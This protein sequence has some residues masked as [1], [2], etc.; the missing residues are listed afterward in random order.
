[1]QEA[2]QVVIEAPRIP[3]FLDLAS[4]ASEL[5]RGLEDGARLVAQIEPRRWLPVLA[6]GLRLTEQ[7]V[8]GL[9]RQGEVLLLLDGLDEVP[10]PWE[11]DLLVESI[12]RMQRYFNPLHA[13]NH[14]IVACREPAWGTGEAFAQFEKVTIQPMDRETI[15]KYVSRW[16]RA[17][18]GDQATDILQSLEKAL[19][20][21]PAL[22]DFAANPQMSTLLA[23]VEYDGPLPKQQ[24]LLFEHFVR[25]LGKADTNR[26]VRETM[27]GHLIALAIEMQRSTSQTG[28][29]LNALKVP[30]AR[31]LLGRRRQ[32]QNGPQLS[33]QT[34]RE[35]GQALLNTLEV[36]TGLLDVDRSDDLDENRSL[37]RFKH[38]TFQE[39]LAACYYAEEGVD[40]LLKHVTDPA[41][42]N[43]LALTCGV[44]T[45]IDEAEVTKLLEQILQIPELSAG[46]PLLPAMLV[47]WAPRV[48]AASVCLAELASYDLEEETL[49]PARRAHNLI[50][51]LLGDVG[52]KVDIQTRARIADGLGSIFDPRLLRE[53]RWVT[54]P[55]G[56]FL[57]GSEADEAWIQER[58]KR[59]VFLEEFWIQRW[60]V[61][62]AEFRQF[63]ED[64]RGYEN[65]AWWQ[66]EAG[67]HWRNERGIRAPKEWEQNR[68]RGNRP[69]TGVSWWEARAFCRWYTSMNTELPDGWAVQLPHEAQWEKAARGGLSLEAAPG[70]ISDTDERYFPWGNTWQDGTANCAATNL[71]HVVPVGLFPSSHS[72]YGL[73]DM[74][75]NI[76]E[77]CLDGFGPY[78]A[79]D[80]ADGIHVDYTHGSVVRGGSFAS[81]PLD[82]RVTYRFGLSRD[83]QDEHV[84]FR[85]VAVST[86]KR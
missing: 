74:A 69:V 32:P 49:S 63:V 43:V 85:C 40:E 3:I 46:S 14:V 62:V 24:T 12:D 28:E 50:L 84:G 36:G 18:W 60:P 61:T 20:L 21:S 76:S 45:Q 25:K 30:K 41:W 71:Q 70:P 15:H 29:P 33:N 7:Q 26:G 1:M 35:R 47:E 48:A 8:Q 4:I 37:V 27:R 11:R 53:T 2:T 23:L 39:Y 31:Q 34:L 52:S 9:L 55:A 54:V 86:M 66:D 79:A 22:G 13:Q 75:G 73:W 72:P 77:H 59:K 81:P 10:D 17:V 78:Q 56:P 38:R 82:L 6:S 80:E 58:P 64:A 68:A 16:C 67:R 19:S 83:T 44:L 65:D 5:L 42:S 51:P 57:Q